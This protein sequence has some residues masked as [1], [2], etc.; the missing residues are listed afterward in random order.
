MIQRSI[1]FFGL[2]LLVAGSLVLA[3]CAT[4]KTPKPPRERISTIP[5]SIPESWEG[6]GGLGG[7]PQTY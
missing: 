5:Q 4:D 2:L 7:M 1:S 6:T 3:S